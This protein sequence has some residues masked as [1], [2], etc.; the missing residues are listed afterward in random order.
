MNRPV[1]VA[2]VGATGAVGETMLKVLAERQFPIG[3][4][5][6]LA[7][8]RSAGNK[9]EFGARFWRFYLTTGIGAGAAAAAILLAFGRGG[10]AL[11]GAS[12]AIYGIRL[13]YAA[14]FPDRQVLLWGVFPIM[15]KYLVAIAIILEL[16]L[17]RGGP[18]GPDRTCRR[19]PSGPRG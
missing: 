11:F 12:A 15:I 4:L 1:T 14:Y 13:A 3:K 6:V 18:A 10:E 5:H 19:S 7:S 9:I 2:V 8:E 16:F 17:A